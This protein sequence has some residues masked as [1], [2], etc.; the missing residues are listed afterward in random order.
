[1]KS[2]FER[3]F[4]NQQIPVVIC[5]DKE[6]YPITFANTAAQFLLN[7]KMTVNSLKEGSEESRLEELICFQ[8][9]F[10]G[11]VF[12]R[13]LRKVGS[14]DCF[15][16]YLT[17]Y[18]NRPLT[19]NISANVV[20]A[21]E[22]ESG[23]YFVLYLLN[24]ETRDSGDSLEAGSLLSAAFH[25]SNHTGRVDDAINSVL[26]LIGSGVKVSRVYVF[27]E[28]SD[29][30]TRNTYEWCAPGIEPAI[31]DLQNLKKDDYNYEAIISS[32][33]YVTDD[34]RE[35]PDGDREILE[36]Q[37]IK[38][39]AILPLIHADR[40]LGYIGFDDCDRYRKWTSAEINVLENVTGMVV[41]LI[42]R[43][44]SER[45]LMRSKEILQTISDN[46][47]S[48][49][50]VNDINT[51]EIIFLNKALADTLYRP[52]D[53]L[54]GNL[55]WKSMQRDM[56]G[57]CPFCP[58]PRMVEKGMLENGGT[59]TWE[60][61]N[62]VNKRWYLVK[63]SFIKWIDGRDVHIE[64]A[65]EITSQKEYEEQL[66]YYASIDM[67]TGA[68]NREWGYKLMREMMAD[69]RP[70]VDEVSL[71]F[72]DLDGLKTVNDTFG[73][74]AGDDMILETVHLIRTCV[75]K[76]DVIC[77]WGGDEI[78]LLLRCNVDAAGNI[79]RKIDDRVLTYNEECNKPYKLG[80]SYGITKLTPKES[81]DTIVSRADQL[82]YEHKMRKRKN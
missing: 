25:A 20:E 71:V 29:A 74:D 23:R 12:F 17:N 69:V 70:D 51:Y 31:Q 10:Q 76:S 50:Y 59:Y 1:M 3:V 58:M 52:A 7:P 79:L 39:L 28:I 43:R 55:C 37:G 64:T 60:F 73:H 66:K 27:E 38:S 5:Q 18:A 6:S 16:A 4:K 9:A 81:I 65:T 77:R 75:R 14:V 63:D 24:E 49:I 8:N 26:A 44:N 61:Q 53:T 34:V 33:L 30:Y 45:R 19:V 78:L 62:T 41:S 57:P 72:I 42:T 22:P 46:L 13:E 11:E 82:M 56:T 21:S 32:G 15:Q 2:F 47:S 67:T 40:P 48:V 36:A 54:M 80:F 35:L 68:Y